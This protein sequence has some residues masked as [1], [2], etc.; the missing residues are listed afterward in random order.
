MIVNEAMQ[1]SNENSRRNGDRKPYPAEKA[2]Q[3]E[4]ILRQRWQRLVFAGALALACIL[5]I[6]FTILAKGW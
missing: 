6:V 3:G 1:S 5:A 4:I 2:R